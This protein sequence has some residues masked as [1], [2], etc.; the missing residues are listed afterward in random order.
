MWRQRYWPNY[1]ARSYNNVLPAPKRRRLTSGKRAISTR[2][3]PRTINQQKT[4]VMYRAPYGTSKVKYFDQLGS[5]GAIVSVSNSFCWH[6]LSTNGAIT[7]SAQMTRGSALNQ[8]LGNAIKIVAFEMRLHMVWGPNSQNNPDTARITIG[9]WN[10]NSTPS[11]PGSIDILQNITF[12]HLSP[13][14]FQTKHKTTILYDKMFMQPFALYPPGGFG[15]STVFL[16]GP[17]SRQV[18]FYYRSK[19]F[20][21]I[22]FDSIGTVER[23]EPFILITSD[24]NA[25][26]VKSAYSIYMRIYFVDA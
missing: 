2:R 21:P 16:Q 17:F 6:L 10:D 5:T 15:P 8:Y 3:R 12:P 11:I 7:G 24:T 14:N 18:K 19:R 25:D 23:G 26:S 4:A 20:A 22:L 1:N 9:Q 13:F